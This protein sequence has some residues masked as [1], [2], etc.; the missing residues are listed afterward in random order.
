MP[1]KVGRGR[2]L[3]FF[4]IGRKKVA[5]LNYQKKTE[6]IRNIEIVIFNLEITVLKQTLAENNVT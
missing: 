1:A 2:V 6:S 3:T 4:F 5:A